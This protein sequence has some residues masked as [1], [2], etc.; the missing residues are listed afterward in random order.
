V[1]LPSTAG[2]FVPSRLGL[3]KEALRGEGGFAVVDVH[4]DIEARPDAKDY[5]LR[6]AL[7]P[8]CFKDAAKFPAACRWLDSQAAIETNLAPSSLQA[9]DVLFTSPVLFYDGKKVGR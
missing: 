4:P 7:N 6:V 5:V 9:Q 3:L 8:D 2:P 1:Q